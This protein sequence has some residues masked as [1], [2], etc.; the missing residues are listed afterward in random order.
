MVAGH[1][2]DAPGRGGGCHPVGRREGHAGRGRG[3]RVPGGA[4]AHIEARAEGQAEHGRGGR[5][6]GFLRGRRVCVWSD[7]GCRVGGGLGGGVLHV[8]LGRD[9]LVSVLG[10][11]LI[12]GC[13][14]CRRRGQIRR[15]FGWENG[16][17]RRV[18]G[19]GEDEGGAGH[20]RGAVC[21]VVGRVRAPVVAADVLRG[22]SGD[23]P[24][25]SPRVHRAPLLH[26][27]H[28]RRRQRRRR[29]SVAPRGKVFNQI[30]SQGVSDGRHGRT[31]RLSRG[32]GLLGRRGRHGR[33]RIRRGGARRRRP[34]VERA[35]ARG[36]ERIAP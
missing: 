6:R 5:H 18:A 22:G 4:L 34:G 28:R 11:V 3:R 33:Q 1:L 2:R 9:L 23:T 24:R 12:Q 15:G 20:L 25:R 35:D 8:R 13:Q 32:R 29:R 27:G 21:A 14:R 26:T 19:A 7:A 10:R 36:R 30:H 16:R 31:R 17:H